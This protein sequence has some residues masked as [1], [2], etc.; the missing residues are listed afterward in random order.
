MA[1]LNCLLYAAFYVAWANS[2]RGIGHIDWLQ[3]LQHKSVW[4]HALG[5]IFEVP[6]RN[7]VSEKWET[8]EGEHEGTHPMQLNRNSEPRPVSEFEKAKL[9]CSTP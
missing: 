8:A 6:G 7:L 3:K 1:L 5:L 4:K 9:S 2:A